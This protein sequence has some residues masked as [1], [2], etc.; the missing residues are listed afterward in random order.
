MKTSVLFA[1]LLGALWLKRLQRAAHRQHSARGGQGDGAT[2]QPE[3]EA[4][5]GS[6]SSGPDPGRLRLWTPEV[7]P[8]SV[9][10][11]EV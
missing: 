4:A 2:P 8:A 5:S 10:Q 3:E 7:K 1:A 9:K 6:L 11:T